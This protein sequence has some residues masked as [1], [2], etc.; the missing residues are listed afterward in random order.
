M[1]IL[2]AEAMRRL[3]QLTI[4]RYGVPGETLMARAGAGV[5]EALERAYGPM[6]RLQV[7][8]L[9]GPGNNGGDGLVAASV[10]RSRGAQVHVGLVG[11]PAR[12]RGDALL[13]LQHLTRDGFAVASVR[14]TKDLERFVASRP[15]WD[16]AID[17]LLGTGAR[18]E[19]E[20]LIGE[21]VQGLRELDEAGTHVVAVDLPTGV[22]ADTGA[23]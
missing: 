21:A 18:G 12:V 1:L 2:T 8:V 23:I 9:C 22:N 11:D 13:H 7:I 14:S 4:E 5:V 10:L 20:G 3:D 6:L 17:A 15:M 16:Y 19:P